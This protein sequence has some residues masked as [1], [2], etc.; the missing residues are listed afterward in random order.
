MQKNTIYLI[1]SLLILLGLALIVW[2]LPDT[3]L[4]WQ[5]G[6]IA[7]TLAMILSLLTRWLGQEQEQGE[8]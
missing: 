8:S 5:A 6:L 3:P 7:V 2:G 1:A 4:V